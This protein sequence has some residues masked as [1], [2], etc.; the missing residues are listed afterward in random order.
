LAMPFF[1]VKYFYMKCDRSESKK[2]FHWLNIKNM[3]WRVSEVSLKYIKRETIHVNF[4]SFFSLLW[5]ITKSGKSINYEIFLTQPYDSPPFNYFQIVC[6]ELFNPQYKIYY[7]YKW[8]AWKNFMWHI[9]SY[10]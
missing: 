8:L 10:K 2:T 3:G 5:E 9:L 6:V 7:I 1:N 4:K